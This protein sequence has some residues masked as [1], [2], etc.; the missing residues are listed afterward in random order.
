MMT[1][2][3]YER[4]AVMTLRPVRIGLS[5]MEMETQRGEYSAVFVCGLPSD[6]SRRRA[7]FITGS[8]CGHIFFVDY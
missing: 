1:G 6:V 2:R 4:T 8:K 7:F 3:R 5:K